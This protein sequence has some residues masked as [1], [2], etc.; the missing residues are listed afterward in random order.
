MGRHS[1]LEVRPAPDAHPVMRIPKPAH[2]SL[3]R[4]SRQAQRAHPTAHTHQKPANTGTAAMPNLT[5]T[6]TYQLFVSCGG[7]QAL[8]EPL[9][10]ERSAPEDGV[11]RRD[12]LVVLHGV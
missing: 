12:D 10:V 8:L 4:A 3:D 5:N 9:G 11:L 2:I 6:P 7:V 1:I